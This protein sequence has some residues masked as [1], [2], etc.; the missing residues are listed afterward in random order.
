MYI[1]TYVLTISTGSLGVR[2]YMNLGLSEVCTVGMRFSG[3][4]LRTVGKYVDTYVRTYVPTMCMV[5][6]ASTWLGPNL[7]TRTDSSKL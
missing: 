7:S 5:D 3:G 4:I 6:D 1:C 2:T